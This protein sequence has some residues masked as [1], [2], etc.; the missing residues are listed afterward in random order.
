[1][2][3]GKKINLRLFQNEEDVLYMYRIYNDLSERN[4][5]D[6]TEIYSPID[7]IVSGHSKY[8]SNGRI[9]MHHLK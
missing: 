3:P 7:R 5:N 1:M 8:T 6:H 4:K 9:K 2:I